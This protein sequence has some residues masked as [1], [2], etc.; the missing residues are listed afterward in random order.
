MSVQEDIELTIGRAYQGVQGFVQGEAN[1]RAELD[2]I[3][4]VQ[5]LIESFSWIPCSERMPE[6][7]QRVYV[8]P[9]ELTAGYF[10]GGR[11]IFD[12]PGRFD[13]PEMW[14]P[15]PKGPEA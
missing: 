5:A 13:D 12:A 1:E 10:S 2:A 3:K 4:R 7:G 11:W 6:E 15:L 8:W 9:Q 14:M